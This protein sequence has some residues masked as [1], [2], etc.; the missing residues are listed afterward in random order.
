MTKL[1]DIKG[2]WDMANMYNFNDIDMWE[3]QF[4][5][6][7]DGWFEGIVVDPNSFYAKDRFVFGMYYQEKSIEL[8]KITPFN[9]RAPFVFRGIRNA[10]GY[11]GS[12]DVIGLLGPKHC[13]NS[14]IITKTA[15]L[16]REN[17]T[18]EVEVLETKIEK[19]KSNIMNQASKKLYDNTVAIKRTMPQANEEVKRQLVKAV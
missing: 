1:V 16:V 5:L 4:L 7:D 11:D 2:Y 15:E 6:Y 17:I 13:G 18:E 19:Y 12:F 8:F 14:H 9:I 3:G 10:N